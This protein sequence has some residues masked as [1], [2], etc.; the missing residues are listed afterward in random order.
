MKKE[1]KVDSK[2][3]LTFLKAST[4]R[5]QIKDL[6]PKEYFQQLLDSKTSIP[7][8]NK[9]KANLLLHLIDEDCL[10]ALLKNDFKKFIEARK[11]LFRNEFISLGVREFSELAIDNNE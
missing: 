5:E 7:E 9:F 4:N 11:V 2:L 10:N 6:N 3:N 1:F 8:K